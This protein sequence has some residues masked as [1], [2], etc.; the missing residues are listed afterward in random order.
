MP[1]K[2]AF[3]E[4]YDLVKPFEWSWPNFKPVE[5]ACKGSKSLLICYEAMDK[6]QRLRIAWGRPMIV[7]S[8]YRS[9]EHNE[10]VKGAKASE[11]M[12]GTAFD[13]AMPI[14]MQ[15]EF[16]VEAK[17]AGFTG[18]GYYNNW[19]HIDIGKPRTWDERKKG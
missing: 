6:L 4:H 9:P 12:N 1:H 5:L 19:V 7:V 10:A 18:I 16:V 14:K 13:I 3:Y 11:H 17:K 2:T 15:D 8:G